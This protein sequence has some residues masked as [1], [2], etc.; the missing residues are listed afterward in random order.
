MDENFFTVDTTGYP[1]K[2]LQKFDKDSIPTEKLAKPTPEDGYRIKEIVNK[3]SYTKSEIDLKFQNFDSKFNALTASLSSELSKLDSKTTKDINK[4]NHW[5]L[6]SFGAV[7][8]AIIALII[9]ILQ[10]IPKK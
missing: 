4:Y 2:E 8:V 10:I 6:G 5:A 9:S 7:I 3:E 1:F